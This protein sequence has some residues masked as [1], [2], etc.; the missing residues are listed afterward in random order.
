MRRGEVALLQVGD[1]F[2]P[3]AWKTTRSLARIG[4]EVWSTFDG[5]S[6]SEG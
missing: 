1:T 5:S 4:A 3:D 6:D 2:P